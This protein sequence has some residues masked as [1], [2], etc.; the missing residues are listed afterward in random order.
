MGKKTIQIHC[1]DYA[2]YTQ[3]QKIQSDNNANHKIIRKFIRRRCARGKVMKIYRYAPITLEIN[4]FLFIIHGIPK[5]TIFSIASYIWSIARF[6]KSNSFLFDF[7]E[8]SY[9]KNN[10]SYTDAFT[11]IFDCNVIHVSLIFKKK[12]FFVR[13]TKSI[14]L[15]AI[16]Y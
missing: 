9:F 4:L 8:L 12:T 5:K 11:Q 6:C 15:Q 2:N 10:N 14:F 7:Y 1:N 3:N 13:I 16:N